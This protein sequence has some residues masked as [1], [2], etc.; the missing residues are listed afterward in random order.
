M[1]VMSMDSG[2]LTR[3]QVVERIMSMPDGPVKER[4]AVLALELYGPA[5]KPPP[6]SV[7]DKFIPFRYDAGGYLKNFL[8]W[9][10]WAGLDDDHP[11]QVE[12][13]NAC[14]LAIRQQVEKR[15]Y[16]NGLLRAEDLH[17]WS[18]DKSSPKH[19]IQNWIRV[20]SGNAIGKTK[21]LSGFVNWYFDCFNSIIYTFHTSATQDELTT[22]KE[23]GKDR[24]GKGLPGKILNT[25]LDVADDRFVVSRS[26]SDAMG[27]GEEKIKGQHNEYLGFVVDEADG[28]Q[29]YVFNAIETMSLGGIS[30]VLMCANPRSRA[31]TFHRLKRYS[32]VKTF[33]ISSLYHPNVVQ[34]K[35]L[36]H[37]AVNRAGLEKRMEKGVDIV[38]KH[39]LERF[40]F[41]LPYDIMVRGTL[42]KS[43]VIFRPKPEFMWTVLGIAPPTAT[44]RTIISV[45]VYEAACKRVPKGGN[46]TIARMGVDCARK[47]SDNGTVYTYWQDAVWRSCEL[48]QQETDSYVD[49]IT[50]EALKLAKKGVTSLHVRVDAGYGAGVIDALRIKSELITAFEDFQVFEVHFGGR[51]HNKADYANVSTEIYYEAAETLKGISILDAPEALEID[52]CEREFKWINVQGKTKKIL[53]AKD[54]FA[55][56][57]KLRSPDDGDGLTL[58]IAPDY[59]FQQVSVEIVTPANARTA[60]VNKTSAIDDLVNVLDLGA[61]VQPST[62]RVVITGWPKTGKSTLAVDMGGGRSTDETL[63]MDW[64]EASAEVAIWFDQPGPW[65]IEGVAVPR[66]LRKW[67]KAHPGEPPPFDRLIHLMTPHKELAPGQVTMGKGIDTVLAELMS[68]LK[69]SGVKIEVRR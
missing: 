53:E 48:A 54:D 13:L 21:M 66:A 15:D 43:G 28:V 33:R 12:V 30:I 59:C 68:W 7:F 46:K 41:T 11:G 22:W 31:T 34:G 27:K 55:K 14:A 25:K 4:A 44:D 47:G 37:G 26:T 61:S 49:V 67:A 6:P 18:P 57:I 24:V 9:E 20:E 36:I 40:T 60:H 50:E 29:E 17:S 3:A 51:A 45:G 62:E 19:K 42:C 52:L 39:D 2:V 64:S 65:V 58:A 38:Q 1:G 63:G 8:G 10:P 69:G 32:Y 16:E 56:R 23:I 35:D 5:P